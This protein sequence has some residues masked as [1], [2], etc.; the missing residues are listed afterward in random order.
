[1]ENSRMTFGQVLAEARRKH[2][3]NLRK[4]A[5][6]VL[7]EDGE[8]I[9]FQY[10]SELE[11]DRRNPPS[12]YLIEQLAN[13]LQIPPAILYIK[14]RRFPPNCDT[15]D[16]YQADAALKAMYNKLEEPVAA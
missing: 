14:A 6:L 10:L 16:V 8:P 2:G 12:D 13:A 3:W 15:D 11:N 1:M 9:T 4:T 5:A 7:K